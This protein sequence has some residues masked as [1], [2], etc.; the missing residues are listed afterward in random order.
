[1]VERLRIIHCFRAPVGG[2]FRHV[3]DL[4]GEQ[5][6]RGHEVGYVLD[7][8]VSDA[9]TEQRLA[10]AGAHLKLGIT[11][12]PMGRLPSLRDLATSRAVHDVARLPLQVE[13][14][15]HSFA[16]LT[17]GPQRVVGVV[18]PKA[19]RLEP[20]RP[21]VTGRFTPQ[22]GPEALGPDLETLA[23]WSDVVIAHRDNSGKSRDFDEIG[24][25]P[26]NVFANVEAKES[27][28]S[29]GTRELTEPRARH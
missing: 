25:V 13:A 20:E 18:E 14:D 12:L 4:S 23:R 16:D 5:A 8:T 28:E 1:M 11:R 27:G 10:K 3:L 17:T 26:R 24:P 29:A 22:F 21:V 7:S 15:R 19:E 9:L 6:A 2:L